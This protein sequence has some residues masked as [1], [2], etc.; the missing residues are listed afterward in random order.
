MFSETAERCHSRPKEEEVRP[1]NV[2]D[3]KVL[4]GRKLIQVTFLD[5][6]KRIIAK[7]SNI[8]NVVHRR[9]ECVVPCPRLQERNSPSL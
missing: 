6:N 2:Y 7:Y 8:T 4:R 1:G 9:L 3:K 5:C